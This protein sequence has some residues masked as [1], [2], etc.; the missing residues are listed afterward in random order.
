MKNF[1][2]KTG[3]TQSSDRTQK[4]GFN[5]SVSKTTNAT[6]EKY[7][8]NWAK[9]HNINNIET[10]AKY[11]DVKYNDVERYTILK[12]YVNS[13]NK[14]CL[15]PITSFELYECYYN[16][17]QS[18][19]VGQSTSIGIKIKSQSIHFLERVFGTKEDP[20]THLPR[21]GVEFDDIKDALF[22]DKKPKFIS[23]KNS[24]IFK[25]QKCQVSL[26]PNGNLIQTNP[27]R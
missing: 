16:K 7:Y 19:L 20:K 23:K 2:N 9:S 17:I 22:N 27:K 25:N 12:N 11:Y 1:C 14:G 5:K 18:E 21:T 13:I 3:L 26:N 6:A 10:L 24:Y 15:S 4:Y 8:E